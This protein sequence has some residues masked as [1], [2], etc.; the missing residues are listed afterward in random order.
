MMSPNKLPNRKRGA[1]S[2]PKSSHPFLFFIKMKNINDQ[3]KVI[4]IMIP[5]VL[6]NFFIT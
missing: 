2:N 1:S 3:T 6:K 5:S 4:I